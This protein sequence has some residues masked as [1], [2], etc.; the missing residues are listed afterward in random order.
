M[1]LAAISCTMCVYIYP[2]ESTYT[3]TSWMSAERPMGPMDVERLV[4]TFENEKQV[5]ID[6]DDQEEIH[7]RYA[8]DKTTA[9]LNNLQIEID[10]YN[11]TFIETHMNGEDTLFL[12]WQVED[13]LYPFTTALHRY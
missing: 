8:S 5:T 1:I 10:G 13:M 6:L 2:D 11:V 7:G 4:I 3:K 12:L 9:T